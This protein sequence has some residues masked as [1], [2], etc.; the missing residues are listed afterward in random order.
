M[1]KADKVKGWSQE[2]TSVAQKKRDRKAK[3]T[4]VQR[5]KHSIKMRGRSGTVQEG[6][7]RPLEGF[8][9]CFILGAKEAI[10]VFKA[11]AGI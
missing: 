4:V 6:L 3:R 5:K 11:K 9:F 2:R 1:G 7:S 8:C 10:N